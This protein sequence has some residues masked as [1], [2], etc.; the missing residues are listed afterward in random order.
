LKKEKRKKEKKLKEYGN[1]KDRIFGILD[2]L[3]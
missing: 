3:E 2:L 1:Y